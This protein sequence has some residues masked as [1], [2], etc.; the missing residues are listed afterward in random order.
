[1]LLTGTR[2]AEGQLTLRVVDN[3]AGFDDSQAERLFQPF[4]RLHRQDDFQGTGIGLTI[5]QRIVQRHG[6]RI[7]ALGSPGRGASFEFT[8]NQREAARPPTLDSEVLA[9][10]SPSGEDLARAT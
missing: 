4:Q 5:V 6:G 2:D 7:S 8:L 9:E 10:G 3:G 1:V